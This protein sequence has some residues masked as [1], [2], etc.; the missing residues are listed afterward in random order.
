[1]GITAKLNNLTVA[2]ADWA[3]RQ[4]KVISD[5]EGHVYVQRGP[6]LAKNAVRT[7]KPR[8]A[9]SSGTGTG[10]KVTATGGAAVTEHA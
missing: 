4:F 7:R 3:G 5:G 8:A 9:R 2:G 1:M 10:D 6:D